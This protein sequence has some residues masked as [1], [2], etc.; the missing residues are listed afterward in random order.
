MSTAGRLTRP[1]ITH[2]KTLATCR[3]YVQRHGQ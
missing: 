3:R 2:L 1:A